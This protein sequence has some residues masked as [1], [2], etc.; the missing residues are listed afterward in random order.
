MGD[1]LSAL[2]ENSSDEVRCVSNG[3]SINIMIG[4][5]CIVIAVLRDPTVK[6]D[7]DILYSFKPEVPT[8]IS[9]VW[10]SRYRLKFHRNI[11]HH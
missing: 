8:F 4:P 10:F 11:Q 1:W 2:V 5:I 6:S 9:T 7:Y 3:Y